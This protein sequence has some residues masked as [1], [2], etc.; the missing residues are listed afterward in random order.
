[1]PRR[2]RQELREPGKVIESK[3]FF[4]ASLSIFWIRFP[5]CQNKIAV[6]PNR[7]YSVSSGNENQATMCNLLVFERINASQNFPPK[8]LK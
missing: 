5:K 7:K 2:R 6:C 1:M 3:L 4:A 8:S